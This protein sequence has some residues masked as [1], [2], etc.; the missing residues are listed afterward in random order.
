MT[1]AWVLWMATLCS[2]EKVPPRLSSTI[3]PSP[4]QVPSAS[5]RWLKV[6]SAGWEIAAVHSFVLGALLAESMALHGAIKSAEH[7]FA[8][9]E[10]SLFSSGRD[11]L[12][13]G[14]LLDSGDLL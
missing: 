10:L 13:W 2:S 5:A 3:M 4:L 6:A 8:T 1:A 7:L 9:Q 14:E 11:H 12:P